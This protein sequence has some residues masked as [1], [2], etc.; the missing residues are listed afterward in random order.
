MNKSAALLKKAFLSTLTLL[1]AIAVFAQPK[2]D[3]DAI[4]GLWMTEGGKS[5]VKVFKKD[6]GKY[7]A[8]VVWLKEPNGDD[9]TPKKD[10][11][12]P[13]T[14]LQSR[15]IK[16]ME[17]MIGF[18]YVADNN[19][20]EG[21][22]L[23]DPESGNTYSGFLEMKSETVINLRG[24]VGISLLGRTSTWIKKPE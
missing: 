21:D 17:F 11:K 22:N 20:W 23:Y 24:Y 13:D 1:F 5:V 10:T 9:G 3:P 4:I 14:K 7:Y 12:N 2:G 15:T 18:E 8:K 16:G 6:D 19:R